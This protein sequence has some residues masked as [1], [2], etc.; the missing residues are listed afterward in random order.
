MEQAAAR[1][2]VAWCV[3]VVLGC[4]LAGE[5]HAQSGNFGISI[6]S[7]R[8]EQPK[9]SG[10]QF[11]GVRSVNNPTQRERESYRLSPIESATLNRGRAQ[12]AP[13]ED[14]DDIAR[15]GLRRPFAGPAARQTTA[16]VP[17]YAAGPSPDA[18]RMAARVP[19]DYRRPFVES[20]RLAGV[21]TPE[22]STIAT[23]V[24]PPDSRVARVPVV[25]SP[26]RL[27]RR[28]PFVQPYR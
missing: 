7:T 11:P 3:A 10:I 14:A 9:F 13:R 6:P 28:D 24:Q 23:R 26:A 27:S 20:D 1:S 25:P 17:V 15:R 16:A 21:A 22:N 5:A 8:F 2:S 4:G 12:P 19:L 18:V